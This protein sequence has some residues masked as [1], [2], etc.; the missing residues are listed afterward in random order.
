CKLKP[1]VL[2]KGGD[3]K[4]EEIAGS[5]CVWDSGGQVEILSFWDGFST[6]NIVERIQEAEQQ[7]RNS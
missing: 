4:P 6:T 1:D 5:K 3:Y 7:E 2:V